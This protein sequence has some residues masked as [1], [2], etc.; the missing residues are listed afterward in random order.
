MRLNADPARSKIPQ[1][2][3]IVNQ[4]TQ[5]GQRLAAR[6]LQRQG[7]GIAHTEAHAEVIGA[8]DPDGPPCGRE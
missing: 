2:R 5:N 3:F 6:F 7:D 1:H 8:D 4:L